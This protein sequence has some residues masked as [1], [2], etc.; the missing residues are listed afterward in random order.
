V[1]QGVGPGE[2]VPDFAVAGCPD[3]ADGL[4]LLSFERTGREAEF[5]FGDAGPAERGGFLPFAVV[6]GGLDWSW[7]GRQLA[8]YLGPGVGVQAPCSERVPAV[9]VVD[10]AGVGAEG[11]SEVP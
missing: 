6:E 7:D 1:V 2:L 4:G 10:E 3:S 11:S 8:D 5:T 9:P